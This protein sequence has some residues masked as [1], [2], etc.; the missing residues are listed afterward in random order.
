MSDGI[1][2][3]YFVEGEIHAAR[4]RPI[5]PRVGELIKLKTGLYRIMDV[6]WVE[7]IPIPEVQIGLESED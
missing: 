4:V 3:D 1:L 6:C 5:V 7:D 2:I